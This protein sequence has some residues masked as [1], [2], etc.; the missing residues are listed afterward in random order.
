QNDVTLK[1]PAFEWVHVQLHQQKG[2]ISLSP[3]TICN[4]AV[5]IAAVQND[6]L[7]GI[8][9]LTHPLTQLT[10][11]TSGAYAGPLEEYLIKSSSR[12]MK[13]LGKV[14]TSS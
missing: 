14:R 4:S 6:I 10:I 2:M 13:E 7:K 5:Y 12:M 11:V 1:M 3:P 8:E 9:S